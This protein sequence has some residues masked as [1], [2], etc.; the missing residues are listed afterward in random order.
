LKRHTGSVSE[1]AMMGQTP[2][3]VPHLPGEVRPS[4]LV[5]LYIA[6]T[7]LF[8][9]PWT[10]LL[11]HTHHLDI[12]RG[13]VIH[14]QMWAPALAA[15]ACCALYRIPLSFLGFHWPGGQAMAWGYLLPVAYATTAYLFVWLTGLA[16]ADFTGFAHASQKSLAIGASAGELNAMLIMTFGVLQSAV[17]ATG[18][19][20]GWRGFL[21]PALAQR[22]NFTGVALVSGVIWALWHYPLIL[23]G[24]YN[25]AA[26]KWVALLC[27]TFMIVTTGA[28]AAWLRLKS[29]SVWPAALLHACHNAVI[30]WLFDSMTVETGRA[31]WFA[32]E[33]GVALAVI[34]ILFAIPIWRN[35]T[36]A[37]A[38]THRGTGA[39]TG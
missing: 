4:V 26:P 24:T 14:T 6:F 18:E 2:A 23:F 1:L 21:V 16:P 25:S 31:S 29:G 17:S 36:S 8:T 5:L 39:S 34:S 19:E 35:G 15:F 10:L 32:G 11:L 3:I 9:V 37:L 20:I 7:V 33:F 38:L 13:F 22:W 27:F 12:G 28:M 30:Q